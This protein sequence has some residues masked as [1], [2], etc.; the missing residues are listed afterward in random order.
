MTEGNASASDSL[1]GKHSAPDEELSLFDKELVN[2]E[3]PAERMN[4]G[5]HTRYEDTVT[6][7]LRQIETMEEDFRRTTKMLQQKLGISGDGV[8]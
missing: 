6:E 7:G 5:H 1:K 3:R 2:G 8:I 4:G